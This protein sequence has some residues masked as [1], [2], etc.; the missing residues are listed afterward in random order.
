MFLFV[1]F[2]FKREKYTNERRR[3]YSTRN[4]SR[5]TKSFYGHSRFL[6]GFYMV[7][8]LNVAKHQFIFFSL[9]RGVIFSANLCK[10]CK[11][12][13][14]TRTRRNSHACTAV[15]MLIHIHSEYDLLHFSLSVFHLSSYV[16][17]R[18]LC[19]R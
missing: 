15:T 19:S 7:T 16:R 1:S 10:C 12:Y 4:T 17:A 8:L 2:F 3:Q 5:S 14:K 6:F 11:V 9:L 18:L 13:A